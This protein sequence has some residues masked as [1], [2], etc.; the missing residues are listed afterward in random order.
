MMNRKNKWI[1]G[2]AIAACVACCAI[3]L[4]GIFFIG[5]SSATI[6]TFF[7]SDQLKEILICGI[8]LFMIAVYLIYKSRK[9]TNECCENPTSDC[10][11]NQCSLDA[12]E[13]K[14]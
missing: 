4:A 8:P 3:P 5:A 1:P 14:I 6:A 2:L 10:N 11:S 12:A 7:A 9:K 13:K